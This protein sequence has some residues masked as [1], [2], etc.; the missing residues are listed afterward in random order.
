MKGP[1]DTTG[2]ALRRA[3][4]D[5]V[6]ILKAF[7]DSGPPPEDHIVDKVQFAKVNEVHSRLLKIAAEFDDLEPLSAIGK[8]RLGYDLLEVLTAHNALSCRVESTLAVIISKE[9]AEAVRKHAAAMRKAKRSS[10]AEN[11][12]RLAQAVKDEARSLKIAIAISEKFAGK[13]RPGVCARLGLKLHKDGW[14]QIG[15]I[16]NAARDIKRGQFL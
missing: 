15:A 5:L 8:R 10:D 13:V 6:S 11:H 2:D 3:T 9:V 12:L 14:P 1:A 7:M 4:G 16:K